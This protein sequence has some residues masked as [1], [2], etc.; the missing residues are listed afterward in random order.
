MLSRGCLGGGGEDDGCGARRSY[1]RYF[2]PT[3]ISL[4]PEDS[5]FRCLVQP[6][7]WS[8][9]S[10]LINKTLWPGIS[11]DESGIGGRCAS[12]CRP[13]RRTEFIRRIYPN[14][15]QQNKFVLTLSSPSDNV[16]I[17]ACHNMLHGFQLLFLC[18]PEPLRLR[19]GQAPE[20]A[21]P[22]RSRR[23][24]RIFLN[25]SQP[26]QPRINRDA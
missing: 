16:V 8:T 2:E 18:H 23:G 14:N 1:S 21:C 3:C 22:E 19:S 10:R 7:Y 5:I 13:Y 24:P 26:T 25:A 15:D 6:L 11:S 4:S 17:G 9:T 20:R 12:S